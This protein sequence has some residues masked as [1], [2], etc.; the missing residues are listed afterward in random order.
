MAIIYLQQVGATHCFREPGSGASDSSLPGIPSSRL[1]VE[2]PAPMVEANWTTSVRQAIEE[3]WRTDISWHLLTSPDH[4]K[5]H[6]RTFK[7]NRN[8]KY[9]KH[10]FITN[11]C[12]IIKV[13]MVLQRQS[14]EGM[15]R[16][17]RVTNPQSPKW[18]MPHQRHR[19]PNRIGAL[20]RS[21]ST[22][23][24]LHLGNQRNDSLHPTAPIPR[25]HPLPRNE[26]TADT[27]ATGNFPHQ[28]RR[29]SSHPCNWS[30]TGAKGREYRDAWRTN[31]EKQLDKKG[32]CK[33]SANTWHRN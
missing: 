23:R 13:R 2:D 11:S 5:G 28:R 19:S 32:L 4:V 31:M 7:K 27:Y 16:I 8:I 14:V 18:K 26:G 25:H 3:L 29:S 1:S 6:I 15:L 20:H 12:K 24:L 17:F 22:Q 21:S 10:K 9:I 30:R 33:Y